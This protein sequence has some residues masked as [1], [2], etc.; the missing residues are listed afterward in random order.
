MNPEALNHALQRTAPHVT[1]PASTAAFPGS[2]GHFHA[3][4]ADNNTRMKNNRSCKPPV[5]PTPT[6]SS[7]FPSPVR[8]AFILAAAAAGALLWAASAGLAQTLYVTGG[9]QAVSKVD[10]NG[11]VSLFATLPANSFP[12]D[13]TFDGI[14]NLYVLAG[15]GISKIT[16]DGT[17]SPFVT[18]P[19]FANSFGLTIDLAGNLYTTSQAGGNK[20]LK[21]TPGGV[22][23][24]FTL[25]TINTALSGL[26]FDALGNLY[27]SASSRDIYKIAPDGSFSTFITLAPPGTPDGLVFDSIGNLYTAKDNTSVVTKIS[28]GGVE[29]NFA[30]LPGNSIPYSLDR[31]ASGTFYVAAHSNGTI[32]KVSPDG[33]TVSPFA[34]VPQ[35]YFVAVGGVPEPST[36]GLLLL[37]G[38]IFAAG[39]SRPASYNLASKRTLTN[40]A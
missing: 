37:T 3:L 7:Q 36:W 21:I 1:A 10:A 22:V 31:D 28:P 15:A 34:T 33:L 6:F 20:V 4:S 35:A 13:L 19:D 14:G 2:L 11:T 24:D 32:Y 18:L 39:R 25:A 40:E 26:A 29:S 5:K 23:S 27:A 17:V 38:F 16:P 30:A 8:S 12:R 9:S